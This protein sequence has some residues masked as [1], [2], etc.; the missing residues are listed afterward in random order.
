ME[1]ADIVKCKNC[2]EE[3]YY[4]YMHWYEGRTYCRR[5][6]YKIWEQQSSWKP[7]ENDYYFPLDGNGFNPNIKY[8]RFNRKYKDWGK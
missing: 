8:N 6:I 7:G 3:E 4:G 1:L 2:G 5:C